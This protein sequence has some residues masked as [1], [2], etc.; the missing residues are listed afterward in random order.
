MKTTISFDQ[1]KATKLSGLDAAISLAFP[2][3]TD[4]QKEGLTGLPYGNVTV[5]GKTFDWL[6]KPTGYVFIPTT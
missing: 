5:D 1:I 4:I 2:E 3:A 6:L